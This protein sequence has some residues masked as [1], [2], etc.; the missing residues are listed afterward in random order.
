MISPD[1]VARSMSCVTEREGPPRLRTGVSRRRRAPISSSF[2]D[3]ITAIGRAWTRGHRSHPETS[4]PVLAAGQ[5]P[6]AIL[7]CQG[8]VFRPFSCDVPTFGLHH[9]LAA[10]LIQL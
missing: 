6:Y 5:K 7:L 9:T 4:L 1:L 2:T 10:K 3:A 8:P